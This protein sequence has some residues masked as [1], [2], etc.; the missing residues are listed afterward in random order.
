MKRVLLIL[1]IMLLI[2]PSP[3]Y[4]DG[5]DTDKVE[6]TLPEEARELAGDLDDATDVQAFFDRLGDTVKQKLKDNAGSILKKAVSVVIVA[7][8]CS[9]L[10]LFG[11]DKTPELVSL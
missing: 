9:I 4:A 5:L 6:D 10:A 2:L 11:G 8:L 3:C 7:V 1:F